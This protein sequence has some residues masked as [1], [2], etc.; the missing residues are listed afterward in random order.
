MLAPVTGST[1]SGAGV[2]PLAIWKAVSLIAL[3]V[4]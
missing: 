1:G 3:A 4:G 2:S